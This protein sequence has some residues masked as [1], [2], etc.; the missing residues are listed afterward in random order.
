[1]LCP[2]CLKTG[3]KHAAGYKDAVLYSCTACQSVFMDPMPTQ[4]MLSA[5]YHDPYEGATTGY[6]AKAEK[7]IRRARKRARMLDRYVDRKRRFLEIGSSGGFMTE[8]MRELGYDVTG[9][10]PDAPG[11]AYAK[12]HY[13]KAR[14]FNGFFQDIEKDLETFD[15]IYCSEVIEHVPDPEPFVAAIARHLEPGGIV[16]ITT[17]DVTHWNKPADITQ[18]KEF[19][20]PSHC[21]YYS[22]QGLKAILARHG[23][24]VFRQRFN[25]KAGIQVYARRKS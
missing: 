17:P 5:L 4:A 14:F 16:N 1:M 8:A 24:D 18:W 13:P 21:L 25:W 11:V 22:P 10:E 23:I 7:K 20:P 19:N 3:H 15:A 12:E 2:A 9:V 6:Y